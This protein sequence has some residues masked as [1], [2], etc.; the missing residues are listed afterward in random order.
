MTQ[1]AP[2]V[3]AGL[4]LGAARFLFT[5]LGYA[6]VMTHTDAVEIWPGKAY[7]LGASY[8]GY[9]T[10]FSIFSE[11]AERVELCLFDADGTET[12][13]VLPEVDAF[14][15]HGMIPNVEPG[16]R[17][18][19]RIH[20]PYDPANGQRCNPNKL[21]LDPY[22]KAID[23]QFHWDQS[24]FGYNFGDPDSRNDDDSAASM[25]KSVVINPFFDWGSDRS[26]KHEYADSVIY[27]AH[28][29]GLTQTHPDVPAQMRGTYAGVAHPAIIDHLKSIGVTAVELMPVHHFANDSTLIDKGLSN[30]W[31][32]NTIGFF[33]PDAKYSANPNPGG[34]V[35]EFKAMVRALHEADI[36]VILDVVYNHT[37]EGNHLGPTLS[38]RGIDNAAYYQIVDDD[39]RYYMDY[40]GTGNSFN[41]RH[42]HSLQLIMDSLRYWVTEM[43]VDGFRFDLAST[44]AREF[45]DVD[46]LATFFELVQQDP[47]VSQVK[48]IAEPWDVGP[49]GYQVGNF[50]PQWTE[51]NGKYR[52]TVRDFWRGEPSTLDEFASR[53]TGSADLYEHTGRRPVASINFV[54]AHDGFTLRDLVSYNEKHNE[55][56]GE[57][58]N[59]GESHNRSWNCGV[60]GPTDDIAI[61]ELRGRQQRN[62]LATLL[63]SQGVPMICHGDELGR[64]QQG[65][66]NVYCQ[67]NELSWIDWANADEE[68][69]VFTRQV[70]ALRTEHP[71][72]RRRRFFNGRPVR[73]RASAGVPDISWFRPDGYEMGDDD[74]E[75]GFGKSVA[76]FINGNGIPDRDPRGQRITDDSFLLCFNAHHEPIEYLVPPAVFAARWEPV[77][78]TADSVQ[79]DG[80]KAIDA[81][82]PLIVDARSTLV[83]R[84]VPSAS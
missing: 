1:A 48:L 6:R 78:Y 30:Y 10:N 17:Y 56:N 41:V 39:N 53:L 2:Y 58:N 25:P 54:V 74:W 45:Y 7:P 82:Q 67:D 64:T 71:V 27:E 72:F 23:G 68:L 70:A 81:G 3:S 11:V 55:A 40:T 75:S 43:R 13:V 19:Y 73:Q 66:N 21:L 32:Y 59:D 62:L 57:D 42:P 18:G 20:G 51:W 80:A 22:A 16:Q 79:V 12:R 50:P 46:R 4:H 76:V 8:D 9:G 31:G 14:V 60:E 36:E 63:L 77:L 44:L 35:Q 49:G 65:N 28:V 37:A 33:A 84:A 83:L 34:Q 52:D 24:L 29:K 69:I 38:F 61:N 47:T 5:V 26:P 15:W